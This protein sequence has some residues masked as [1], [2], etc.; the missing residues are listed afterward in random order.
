[1][2]VE[3]EGMETSAPPETPQMKPVRKSLNP[4]LDVQETSEEVDSSESEDSM[5]LGEFFFMSE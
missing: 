1:M 2:E 5:L 3:E 4:F